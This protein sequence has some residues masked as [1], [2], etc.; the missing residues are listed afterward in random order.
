MTHL[1]IWQV[2][3]LPWYAFLIAWA[4][5]AIWV[6][7]VKVSEPAEGRR[8]QTILL[9]AGFL[10]L[11]SPWLAAGVLGERFVAQRHWVETMGIG[12]TSAGSGLAIWARA[13]LG[14]NWSARVT[15]K[16][17]HE[18]IRR[19]PY[20]YVRHPIYS[21]LALAVIGTAMVVGEW[22]GLIAIPLII[23]AESMKARRE[24]QYM[25]AEFGEGYEQYRRETGFLVPGW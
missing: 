9:T 25:V 2:E 10:L 13:I 21:G 16:V 7:P 17:G 15:R 8:W 24:E 22:R 20:A 3:L 11:F 12:L 5:G 14:E 6:K 23:I 19:G 18:L 1:T 4:V